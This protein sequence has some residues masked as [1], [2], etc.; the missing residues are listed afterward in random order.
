M[1]EDEIDVIISNVDAYDLEECLDAVLRLGTAYGVEVGEHAA[2][3]EQAER[4]KEERGGPDDETPDDWRYDRNEIPA[5]NEII[6]NLF[7]ALLD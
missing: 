3:L 2:R 7:G 1:L 4:D 6:D 5:S